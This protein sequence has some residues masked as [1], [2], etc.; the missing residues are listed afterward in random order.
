[1]Y[2]V[3]RGI[4]CKC[5]SFGECVYCR[6]RRLIDELQQTN[7]VLKFRSEEY[8]KLGDMYIKHVSSLNTKITKLNA[9]LSDIATYA[10]FDGSGWIENMKKI[11]NKALAEGK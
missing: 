9:A 10:V 7:E 3:G 8:E 4:T 1:M 2:N 5:D 6:E 11:A